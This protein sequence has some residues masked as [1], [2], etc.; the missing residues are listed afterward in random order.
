MRRFV[1]L[2][3]VTALIL[4]AILPEPVPVTAA[5][6]LK[7]PLNQSTVLC[8]PGVYLASPTDCLPLG[9]SDYLT[10]MASMGITFPLR[11]LPATQ[12]DLGL[13]IVPYSYVRLSEEANPVYANLDDAHAGVH[14]VRTIDPGK[15]KFVSYTT[16]EPT[17][18]NEKPHFYQLSSGEWVAGGSRWSPYNRFSGLIFQQTPINSFGWVL[19]FKEGVRSKQTP[20]LSQ[21]DYTSHKLKQ[22]E[23]VQIYSI[24]KVGSVN[25]YMIGPDEWVDETTVGRVIINTTPP[26]GVTNG[27][28]IEVNLKEQTLSVYDNYQLVF[29]TLIAT[30]QDGAWTR[31][32]LFHIYKKYQSTV[33]SAAFAVDRSDFYYL[34]DV[35]YTMYYD[36]ARALHGAYWRAFMGYTQSHGCVNMAIADAHWL[37]D[38]ANEGEA[39]YVWDPSGRTPTDPSAYSGSGAP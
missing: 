30:G 11:P 31:P 13:G 26:T 7:K 1:L 8:L 9:P 16:A 21:N 6:Q 38:W 3:L 18:G 12:V 28:W 24:Q 33:M 4:S 39:V 25:W 29:A 22:Y 32:G 23:I 10:R 37:F 34:D 36:E 17:T 15:L 2:A 35:P 20:S 14:S 5:D 19:P 27:R